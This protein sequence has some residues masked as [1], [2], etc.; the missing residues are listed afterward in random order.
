MNRISV[1]AILPKLEDA[2]DWAELKGVLTQLEAARQR[3]FI[4]ILQCESYVEAMAIADSLSAA[5]EGIAMDIS[6]E[7]PKLD[8]GHPLLDQ[9]DALIKH[10]EE[11]NSMSTTTSEDGFL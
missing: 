11:I 7:Q 4:A 2:K 8:A 9:G 6:T 3:G 1:I 5:F 10:A